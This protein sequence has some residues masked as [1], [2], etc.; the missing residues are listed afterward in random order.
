MKGI[1]DILDEL[2]RWYQQE[3]GSTVRASLLSK[4]ACLELCGWLESRIDE[5]MFAV[6]ERVGVSQESVEKQVVE[7]ISGFLYEKHMRE[8]LCRLVGHSAAIHLETRFEQSHPGDLDRLK[9]MLKSLWQDRV[10]LAHESSV[11]AAGR[12]MKLNAPSWLIAQQKELEK[13]LAEYEN[14]TKT[15]FTREIAIPWAS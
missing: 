9:S 1:E 3:A 8:M 6:G 12:Q 13:L 10:I 5:V 11:S 15:A 2:D 14:A 7:R 4:L